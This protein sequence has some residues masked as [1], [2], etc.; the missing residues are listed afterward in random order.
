M[1]VCVVMK[2][3]NIGSTIR[4]FMGMGGGSMVEGFMDK[5]NINTDGGHLLQVSAIWSYICRIFSSSFSVLSVFVL[6]FFL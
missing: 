3:E 5:V 1:C 4:Q 6:Y 2:P